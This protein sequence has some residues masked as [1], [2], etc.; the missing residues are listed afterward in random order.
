MVAEILTVPNYLLCFV[1]VNVIVEKRYLLLVLHFADTRN[2]RAD[3][4]FA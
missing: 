4:K 1:A 3:L 2:V